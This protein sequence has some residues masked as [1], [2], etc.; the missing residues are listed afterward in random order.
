MSRVG[1]V[2]ATLAR[3]H[4]E[5]IAS[6]DGLALLGPYA[7][8]DTRLGRHHPYHAAGWEQ[9]ALALGFSGSAKQDEEGGYGQYDANEQRSQ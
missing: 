3:Q 7:G 9:H 8:N 2:A 1:S 5:N 4:K 6:M